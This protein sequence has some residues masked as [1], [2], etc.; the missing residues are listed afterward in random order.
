[1][2]DADNAFNR[3]NRILGLQEV[4]KHFPSAFPFIRSMYL[5]RS[6]GWYHQNPGI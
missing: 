4:M 1:M 6:N 2:I 3:S 5:C